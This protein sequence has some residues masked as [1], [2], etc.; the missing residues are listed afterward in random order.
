MPQGCG[1]FVPTFKSLLL[2]QSLAS[3][4]HIFYFLI[5]TCL[6]FCFCFLDYVGSSLLLD[7]YEKK[8]IIPKL[9]L[10]F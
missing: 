1:A 2:Y 9:V 3:F 4:N 5:G 6:F 10:L 7:Q 8:K